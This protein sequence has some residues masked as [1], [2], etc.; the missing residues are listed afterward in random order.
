M[1]TLIFQ[2]CRLSVVG[3]VSCLP[4]GF[5]FA[6]DT[7]PA[8]GEPAQAAPAAPAAAAAATVSA[9]ATQTDT[10]KLPAGAADVVKLSRA[11]VGEDVILSYVQNSGS[12]YKLSS[13][14][15]IRLKSD[16]VSDRVIHAMLDQHKQTI[17]TAEVA[18][19]SAV[20]NQNNRQSSAVTGTEPA[21]AQAP[22]AEAPLVP[23]GSSTYVIPYPAATAAY[24]GYYGPSYYP[25]YYGGPV[26]SFGFGYGGC[27]YGR[28]YYGH[29][30]YGGGGIYAH[31]GGGGGHHH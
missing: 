22:A 28:S 14:D 3:A 4:M 24:Y 10:V 21:P 9:P 23:S 31:G 16:G 17:E 25:Y 29:G 26:V 20:A 12:T 2:I 11:Q 18:A 1:K 5:A 6:A 15:I 7:N 19:A 27:Y 30:Y 8:P 13:E